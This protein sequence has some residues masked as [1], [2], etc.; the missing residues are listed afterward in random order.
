MTHDE[1]RNIVGER[2]AGRTRVGKN[3]K[4]LL[5][6]KVA[7]SAWCNELSFLE[8]DIVG[9]LV[10]AGHDVRELRFRVD[11]V[12]QRAPTRRSAPR[13]SPERPA[14]VALSAELESRLASVEDPN[15]RAAIAEAAR[16]CLKHK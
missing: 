11:A 2:I 6:I 8:D 3:Y 7:S 9:K 10:R 5:T 15:L 4:G 16:A 13:P 14:Q 12:G 1:W